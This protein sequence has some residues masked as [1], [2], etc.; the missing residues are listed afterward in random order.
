VKKI[1]RILHYPGS[2]WRI[3]DWI[4]SHFP[5]HETYLEPFMGSL[6]ILCS[7]KRSHLETVNDLD[8]EIV[9]LFRMIREYP[10]ELA[11]AIRHTP[12]SRQEFYNSYETLES[13]SELEIA[14]KLIVRLW[15]GRGGK[16]SHR[17]GWRSMIE[18]NGPLPGK[19]W[20]GFPD[21]IAAVAERLMGVQIENQC[22]LELIKR[23]NRKNVL[24]YADP[25]YVCSTR[26]TSSYKCEMTDEQHIELLDALEAH[27]GYVV[28]SGYAN[29]IYDQKLAHWL[30]KTKKTQ[31]EA[32][33]NRVEVLWINP[34]AAAALGQEQLTLF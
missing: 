30:R 5:P 1:P 3:A 13:D 21:K 22:A 14:R 7:K 32:G 10:D 28:L 25:P 16:T 6:A 24:I 2:K 26:T 33:A 11:R 29:D 20:L 34:S 19:E 23:Y 9:N 4:I 8:N 15:Q 31:A 17:T 27:M 12:H 18:K